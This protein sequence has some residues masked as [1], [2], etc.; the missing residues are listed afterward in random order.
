MPVAAVGIMQCFSG[1]EG[2]LLACCFKLWLCV[3]IKSAEFI[4]T[5]LMHIRVVLVG[6]VG[7]GR[8]RTGS[9]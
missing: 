5:S 4:V 2:P 3:G 7:W 8:G 9:L 1:C 6:A